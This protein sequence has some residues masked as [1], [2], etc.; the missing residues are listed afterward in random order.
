MPWIALTLR[1]ERAVAETFSD[2]L[3]EAGAQSVALEGVELQTLSALLAPGSE[4]EALVASAAH[5]AGIAVPAFEIETIAE[6]DWVRASQAQFAP[7]EIGERLWIGATWHRPP[8]NRITVRIDPGLAFGTGSHP[9]TRLVLV[10]LANTIRGG[11]R[12]LDYGCGS[13][14]LA[15]AAAKLGAR[16]VDAVDIDHRAVETARANAL[17]NAVAPTATLP[18]ALTGVDYDV[19]VAN[20][21]AQPLIELAPLF[22]RLGARVALSGILETQ[23]AETAQAYAPWFDMHIAGSDEGWVLL[24]GARK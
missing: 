4:P 21:L 22:A 5:A 9:S 23:A 6:R 12:V 14:I 19:I 20:I 13:G 11:E 24:A 1:I 10:F 3:L 2:S 8:P 7:L 17:A 18:D 15:I 16:Q